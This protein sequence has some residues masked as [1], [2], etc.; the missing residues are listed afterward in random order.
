[1]LTNLKKKNGRFNDVLIYSTFPFNIHD[2]ERCFWSKAQRVWYCLPVQ[3]LSISKSNE[4]GRIKKT[5]KDHHFKKTNNVLCQDDRGRFILQLRLSCG[6]VW[7]YE[8]GTSL[9]WLNSEHRGV[10]NHRHLDCM[11]NRL[12]RRTSKH[13]CYAAL[14]FVREKNR[15]SMD[16]HTKGQ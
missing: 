4:M 3:N 11:F 13:Q 15:W 7:L 6:S 1:M 10:S 12:F 9:Q 16:S 8:W 2:L 5:L 14:T